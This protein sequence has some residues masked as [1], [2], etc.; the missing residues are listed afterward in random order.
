MLRTIKQLWRIIKLLVPDKI[1]SSN[2]TFLVESDEIINAEM[3]EMQL[4]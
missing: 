3:I 2:K 4:F 1:W